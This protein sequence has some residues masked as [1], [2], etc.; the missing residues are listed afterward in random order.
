MKNLVLLKIG[1]SICTEK[2]KNKF[3]VR[4]KTVA[5]I[6]REINDARKEKEFRLLVVNGAGPFGHTN[7][8]EYGINN[9]LS[10]EKDYE[11][12]AKTVNDCSYLNWK[13]SDIMRK[14]GIISLPFPS[15]SVVIQGKRKIST[16]FTD[17]LKA[18]W[19][20]NWSIV[21]VMN[22]TMVADTEMKGS[23]VSG[24]AVLEHI[25]AR[26]SP[27][28]MI[29]VTDVDGIFTGDPK[30]NSRARLIDKISKD[31]YGDIKKHISGSSNVD[32]TGGMLGKV[33]KMLELKTRTII[34]NGNAPGRVRK[35]LL[36]ETVRGTVL[37]K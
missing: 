5:R 3:R 1:G 9:G 37:G 32:V 28:F 14:E 36:G 22:G 17:S 12:F 24:D 34:I 30:K 20:S 19:N 13:V 31:G 21:P 2:G 7:V 8:T 33:E 10:N 35:A 27:D 11:G 4:E 18:L 15:S 25:A 26:F 16:F 23:V 6:A 29:F